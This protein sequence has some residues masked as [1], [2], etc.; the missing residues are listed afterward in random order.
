MVIKNKYT[1]IGVFSLITLF[2]ISFFVFQTEAATD[3]TNSN[4]QSD[5]AAY[6]PKFPEIPEELK[7]VISQFSNFT[8]LGSASYIKP[9]LI[10]L[11]FP[12]S[13]YAKGTYLI[14]NAT[15]Q[16]IASFDRYNE[17][18]VIP[19][20]FAA[21]N[22]ENVLLPQM[23]DK[24][25]TTYTQFPASK[26][27]RTSSEIYLNMQPTMLEGLDF[28][29]DSNVTPPES[30]S[31][32]TLDAQGNRTNVVTRKNFNGARIEFPRTTSS[33]WVITMYHSQP[34]RITELTPIETYPQKKSADIIRYLAQS[35]QEYYLFYSTINVSFIKPESGQL[36]DRNV[37]PNQSIS[38]L[39]I[40]PNLSYVNPDMDSDT[41]IDALD[42]CPKVANQDQADI[43]SSGVGDACEDFDLDSIINAV[44]NCP[45]DPNR[46]QKDDD[47]DG[48]GNECDNEESRIV[49]QYSWLPWVG[50]GIV[51]ILTIGLFYITFKHTKTDETTSEP[52][53]EAS[54]ESS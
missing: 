48:I 13:P 51:G 44:D 10:E 46:A 42:N 11:V 7:P 41:I 53:S 21:S 52:H 34:V 47:A 5:T 31:I 9:E 15:T 33:L 32:D 4:T 24:K 19:V 29:Y 39:P 30:V 1:R 22:S 20:T 2:L 36:F 28:A 23:Y 40:F 38:K 35:E 6:K 49:E 18:R 16:Q 12:E 8:P 26:T 17:V 45:N 43:D 27:G 54:N 37:T 3:Q 25:V 14:Y 50:I